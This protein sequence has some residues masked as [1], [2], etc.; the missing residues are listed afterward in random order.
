M[1]AERFSKIAVITYKQGYEENVDML[2]PFFK[3]KELQELIK[4]DKDIIKVQYLINDKSV[5]DKMYTA[6]QA[7]AQILK[8]NTT[9]ASLLRKQEKIYIYGDKWYIEKRKSDNIDRDR[10]LLEDKCSFYA[11]FIDKKTFENS[12]IPF[13]LCCEWE[14]FKQRF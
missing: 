10:T 7:V 1:K 2:N 6:N 4:N 5:G 8:M 12:E 9:L 11:Q 13:T 14:D 3:Q